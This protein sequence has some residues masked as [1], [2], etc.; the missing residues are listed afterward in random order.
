[1]AK[2]NPL[3]HP[4]CLSWPLWTVE[5]SQL[6]HVPFAMTLVDVA[7]PQRIVEVGTCTGVLYSAFC[8]AVKELGLGASCVGVR[9]EDG[10]CAQAKLHSIWATAQKE[11]Y[12]NYSQL[13]SKSPEQAGE[14]FPNGSIDLLHLNGECSFNKRTD[15]EQWLPR[16]SSRGLIM[17]SN[18]NIGD[19]SSGVVEVWRDLKNRFRTFEFTHGGGLGVAVTGKDSS[20]AL[21]G[22]LPTSEPAAS[23]VREFFRQ[24]GL[25]VRLNASAASDMSIDLEDS[26]RLEAILQSRA[27]R[28]V[29]RYVRFK[30]WLTGIS[31]QPD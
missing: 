1:M 21:K 7:R 27:W 28:W 18:K 8:Q 3:D 19:S 14:L 9:H 2:F 11:L 5:T 10:T 15:L 6:A 16:M 17:V 24:Q 4:V 25:R 31:R 26:R 13:I 22:L 20:G 23:L 12:S 29:M 30:N